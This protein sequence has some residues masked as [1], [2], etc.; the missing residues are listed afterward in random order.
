MRHEEFGILR[1]SRLQAGRFLLARRLFAVPTGE[2]A[3]LQGA[4]KT[5][6]SDAL[7]H[8]AYPCFGAGSAPHSRVGWWPLLLLSRRVSAR[9]QVRWA[10]EGR[11][12]WRLRCAARNA[13]YRSRCTGPIPHGRLSPALGERLPDVG[14][15]AMT[16]LR[17]LGALGG[18]ARPGCRPYLQ[19]CVGGLL[20]T[21]LVLAVPRC[22]QT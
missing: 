11:K 21:S 20:G 18:D 3:R 14:A 10:R 7:R 5:D 17:Q 12:V 1:R 9:S 16:I 22:G 2:A 8:G 15:T 6:L 4:G 19:R 13:E